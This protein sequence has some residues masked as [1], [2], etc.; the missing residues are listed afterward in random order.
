VG[1]SKGISRNCVVFRAK[2]VSTMDS[3]T[4]V[5]SGQ[6]AFPCLPWGSEAASRLTDEKAAL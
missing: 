6:T 5:A 1:L 4:V 2:L 3:M